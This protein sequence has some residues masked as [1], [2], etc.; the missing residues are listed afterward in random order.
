MSEKLT[1]LESLKIRI[2]AVEVLRTAKSSSTYRKLSKKTGFPITVLS[3]YVK[4]H[5]LPNLENAKLIIQTLKPE[6]NRILSQP[7]E[8]KNVI[9][10]TKLKIKMRHKLTQLAGRR[11]TKIVTDTLPRNIA[12]ATLLSAELDIPLI[13]AGIKT[14]EVQIPKGVIRR[15][16]NVFIIAEKDELPKIQKQI[17]PLLRRRK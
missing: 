15:N 3:R 8:E 2:A 17:Q 4:G 9:D 12:F 5:I 14:V 11:V 10:T 7:D 1:H 16:D 13:I 6:I